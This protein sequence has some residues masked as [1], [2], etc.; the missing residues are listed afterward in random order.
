LGP[1]PILKT[2]NHNSN[3]IK[4]VEINNIIS[5]ENKNIIDIKN[6]E[7]NNSNVESIDNNINNNFEASA[8][9]DA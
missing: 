8:V 1:P 2:N 5:I 6:I 3:K 7:S 9:V 4:K